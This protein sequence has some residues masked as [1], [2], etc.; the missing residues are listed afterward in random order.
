MQTSQP[1]TST[2]YTDS[3]STNQKKKWLANWPRPG[4]VSLHAHTL[5]AC[6][7]LVKSLTFRDRH[8]I[9]LPLVAH[10]AHG[11]TLRRVEH[12]NTGKAYLCVT[13]LRSSTCTIFFN[14]WRG[15]NE[16]RIINM[17]AGV[18]DPIL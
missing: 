9:F 3:G 5:L 14:T 16:G 17:Q 6:A 2:A 15:I 18:D 13:S 11:I 10:A 4:L 7:K 8:Q 12:C 1:A